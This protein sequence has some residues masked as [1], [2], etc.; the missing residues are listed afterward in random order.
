M[1]LLPANARPVTIAV[2]GNERDYCIL[3]PAEPLKL[4]VDGPGKLSVISRC[5][6]SS[7]SPEQQQ[8]SVCV[9]EG[10]DTLKMQSTRTERSDAALTNSIVPLKAVP[11]KSRKFTVLISDGS[12]L[13]QFRSQ[14][15]PHGTAL[16][17]LFK[18][19][20][21]KGKLVSIEPLSYDRIVTATINENQVAYY[22]ASRARPVEL[23]VVGPTKVRVSIRLNFDV[24]MQGK[25]KFS[26]VV[27]SGAERVAQWSLEAGRADELA[28]KEWREVVPGKLISALF[29]VPAGEHRYTVALG[30]SSAKSV[31]LR[32]SVPQADLGNEE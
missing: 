26:V 10:E 3:S 11:G 17:L 6:F 24:S 23:R 19:S 18:P 4:R 2:G 29:D 7:D 28:Y 12:H 14:G 21:E 1:T 16:R 27:T 32:F 8:Y 31:S 22:V 13:L 15:A 9:M 30:E 5:L 20:K 25:Q